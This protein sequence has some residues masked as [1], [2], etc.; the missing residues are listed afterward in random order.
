MVAFLANQLVAQP[1]YASVSLLA[2]DIGG[3]SKGR[4]V[5]PEV[6]DPYIEVKLPYDRAWASVNYFPQRWI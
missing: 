2:Q 1:D 4:V 3:Q 6:A 5:N